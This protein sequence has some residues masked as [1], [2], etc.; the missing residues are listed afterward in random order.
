MKSLTLR[1]PPLVR[2]DNIFL[3]RKLGL[4]ALLF[5]SL[6]FDMKYTENSLS[7]SL[8]LS[9]CAV[10]LQLL[11]VDIRQM[12]KG[13]KEATKEL[14]ENKHNK[15]LKVKLSL[16]LKQTHTHTLTELAPYYVYALLQLQ[17]FCLEAEPRVT[18]LEN[19]FATANVSV[20]I[21]LYTETQPHIQC[22][23]KPIS[24]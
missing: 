7:L 5:H 14:V 3:A 11:G 21:Y 2:R 9:L 15:K 10:S 23:H 20:F 4:L 13:L 22:T 8:P 6:L 17:R 19:D 18:R 1:K 12:S 24:L 16:T